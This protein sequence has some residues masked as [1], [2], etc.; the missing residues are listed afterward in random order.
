MNRK[1]ALYLNTL[2]QFVFVTDQLPPRGDDGRSVM[3]WR[4]GIFRVCHGQFELKSVSARVSWCFSSLSKFKLHRSEVFQRSLLHLRGR[5]SKMDSTFRERARATGYTALSQREE[6]K[7]MLKANVSGKSFTHISLLLY[8]YPVCLIWKRWVNQLQ[9]QF[10]QKHNE[11]S[12]PAH[13]ISA[14]LF[15]VN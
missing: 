10:L 14:T 12:R 13:L 15:I 8:V 5:Q 7:Y 4:K 2:P 9:L 1:Y 6:N 3:L 11:K